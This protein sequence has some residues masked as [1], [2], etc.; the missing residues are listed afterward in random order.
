MSVDGR[1]VSEILELFPVQLA[2]PHLASTLEVYAPMSSNTLKPSGR[3]DRRCSW[4]EEACA[5]HLPMKNDEGA[6]G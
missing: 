2:A 3:S 5:I 4:L 6:R 1:Q